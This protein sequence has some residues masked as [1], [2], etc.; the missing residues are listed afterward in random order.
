MFWF[1]FGKVYL[2]YIKKIYIKLNKEEEEIFLIGKFDFKKY[3]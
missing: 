1:I 2:F 3:K